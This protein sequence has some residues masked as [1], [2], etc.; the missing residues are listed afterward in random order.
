[1]EQRKLLRSVGFFLILICL[2]IQSNAQ[3][4]AKGGE[5][6]ELRSPMIVSI[7]FKEITFLGGTY[8]K[9]PDLRKYVCDGVDYQ[10][11]ASDDRKNA[12][13]RKS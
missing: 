3:V 8:W 2:G 5:V 9:F 12:V 4:V 10:I 7:P 6:F 13:N 11:A 1:M